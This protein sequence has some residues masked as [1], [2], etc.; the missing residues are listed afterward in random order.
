MEPKISVIMGV[1]NCADTLPDAI[2]SIQ[3]QAVSDW[4]FII[5]DDGS[6]D[7]TW[8]TAAKLQ[9]QDSRIVLLRNDKNLGLNATLNKCLSAARGMY[10]ARMD[11][12]DVCAPDRF[13]K[14]LALYAEHPEAGV[15]SCSMSFFDDDGVFGKMIYDETPQPKDLLHG[16]QFCHAGAIM[17]R[18]ILTA[19]GG[20]S[21]SKDTRRVEDYDLWVRMYAAGYRGFNTQE[22]LYSMRD[23]RNA[24]LRRTFRSRINE[25]KVILRAGKAFGGGVKVWVYAVIPLLKGIC[26]QFVYKIAHKRRL[27]QI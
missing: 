4:E 10:I 12:D 5:C 21:E 2:A 19:L 1:Y 18:D 22:I 27:N 7:E 17:R 6:S 20:Y 23:D 14:E 16:S 24:V 9:K 3:A 25:S 11:G 13:E 26:P 15:I 8:E